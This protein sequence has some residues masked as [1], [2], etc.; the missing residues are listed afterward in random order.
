MRHGARTGASAS[1]RDR[2]ARSVTVERLKRRSDFQAAA[3]GLRVPARAFVLQARARGDHAGVVR[4]GLTVSRQVGN[5]VERN[6]VRRR[7]R[8]I[9]RL[10]TAGG[11]EGLCPGHDYVLIGRRAVLAAPFAE[12]MRDFD[13]TLAR[14]HAGGELVARVPTAYMRHVRCP[15]RRNGARAGSHRV[16]RQSLRRPSRLKPRRTSAE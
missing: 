7:L 6:R 15:S 8:E 2:D 11:A 16:S 13:A 5:A 1:V 4:V 9:V 14:V 3:R 12:L 10:S